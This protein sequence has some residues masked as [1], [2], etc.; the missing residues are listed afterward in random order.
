MRKILFAIVFLLLANAGHAQTITTVG[1]HGVGDGL[2]AASGYLGLPRA[3]AVSGSGD[4]FIADTDNHRIR[5]VDSSGVITTFAGNGFGGFQRPSGD[6]GPLLSASIGSPSS[7]TFDVLGNLYVTEGANHRVRKIS[8]AGVISTVA[9]NGM[10]GFGGDGGPAVSALLN[11]PQWIVVA[12]DGTMYVA[13]AANHR[14][15]KIDS[16]G[17]ISTV[18]GTGFQGYTGDGGP[19]TMATLRYPQALALDATGNLFVADTR[20][21]RVRKI[22]TSGIISSI[23]DDGY[24][25][26]SPG[27]QQIP[28]YG[29]AQPKGLVVMPNGDLIIADTNRNK[30]KKVAANGQASTIAGV[31]AGYSGDGGAAINADLYEP[32]GLAVDTNGNLFIADYANRRI[33]KISP[34]GMINLIAG[35]GKDFVGDGLQALNAKLVG[36]SFIARDMDGNLFFSD[37]THYRI[38]KIATDGT[39][40]TIAGNGTFGV[41]GDGAAATSVGL[42]GPAGVA[43]DRLGNVYFSEPYLSKVWKVSPAGVLTVFAGNGTQGYSGDGGL[44]TDAMLSMPGALAVDHAG[45]VYIAGG[46]YTTGSTLRRVGVDGIIQAI[47]VPFAAGSIAIDRHG[48]LFTGHSDYRVY[49]RTPSGSVSVFA[50]NGAPGTAG[51]GGPAINA[52]IS[53]AMS[54]A[55]DVAGNVYLADAAN[56]RIRKIA[57]NGLIS[58][59]AG[60]NPAEFLDGVPAAQSFLQPRGIALSATRE[61]FVVDT[62][63]SRIRKILFDGAPGAPVGVTAIPGDSQV[64][65]FF[66]PPANDGGAVVTRY[67]AD[68]GAGTAIASSALSPITVT[69]LANGASYSCSVVAV[70][71]NGTGDP[72]GAVTASPTNMPAT[73]FTGAYSRKQHGAA[74]AFDQ[75]LTPASSSTEAVVVEPRNSGATHRLVFGFTNVISSVASATSSIGSVTLTYVGKEVFV[76]LSGVPNGSRADVVISG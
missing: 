3:V 15:R 16:S 73:A 5:K 24:A 49:K 61:L 40:S 56:S 42:N 2:P 64:T 4:I 18:A 54:L 39:I 20:N 38:R 30:I 32:N 53:F 31:Y 23:A 33:R 46:T 62:L 43:V 35:V 11:E 44:A 9:G 19:A 7:V 1:G 71:A 68:C 17:T 37:P 65:L 75:Q 21:H 55:V 8:P 26:S 48:N 70:N 51:D 10:S 57:P 58:T 50:G 69:G 76:D 47:P 25:V 6:G 13:D 28:L 67:F 12:P 36:P 59:I 52:S 14:I 66:S 22:D 60:A 72:S 29:L 41:G 74:G 45:N 27:N 34:D 63:T